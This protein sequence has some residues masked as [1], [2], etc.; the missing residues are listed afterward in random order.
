MLANDSTSAVKKSAFFLV[1][2]PDQA[3]AELM[4]E[5]PKCGAITT[6]G[7]ELAWRLRTVTCSECSLSMRLGDRDLRGLR[8]GLRDQ[9]VEA[10][11]RMDRL[12]DTDWGG[13]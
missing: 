13:A 6:Y 7:L 12:I 9:L 1:V 5:C 11:M 3:V 2:H 4:A 8:R 10:R